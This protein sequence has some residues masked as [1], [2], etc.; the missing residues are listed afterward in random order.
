MRIVLVN[1]YFHPDES[2]TSRMVSSL[3]FGLASAG[4]AVEI[5][6]SR[7]RHDDADAALPTAETIYGVKVNRIGTSRFGRARLTGRAADY[8]SFHASAALWCLKHVR[9]GDIV[10]ACTDPPLLSVS[11]AAAT[12]LRRGRLVNWLHDVFPEVAIELGLVARQGRLARLSLAVRDW[13]LHRAIRNVVPTAAMARVLNGRG[14]AEDAVALIPYWSEEDEI[15]PIAP[16]E[17]RLRNEWGFGDEAAFVVGYSGNF[18]RAHEFDTVLDAAEY[19]RDDPHIHFLLVGGGHGRLAVEGEIA[20]RGLANVQ[21]QPL[22]PRERLAESLSV[23]DVHLISLRPSL[24]PYVVP[25]KLYGIMA[26]AR[27]VLFVGAGDGGVATVLRSHGIGHS[28]AIGA[29]RALASR[30]VDMQRDRPARE[31]MGRRAREAFERDHLRSRAVS[32]WLSL[33]QA[34]AA[35]ETKASVEARLR[36]SAGSDD[37]T[38]A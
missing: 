8:A 22:Q 11:V 27:P 20:R 6:T 32:A 1:R 10:I 35:E 19:L 34:I 3:A 38:S 30:I 21:L 29:G 4:V 37:R 13:S 9:R 16:V 24:E 31:G 26:V 5:L 12:A 28:V 14:V 36:Y 15:R 7:H 33:L 17:N 23:A 18:G 25:S 2:A